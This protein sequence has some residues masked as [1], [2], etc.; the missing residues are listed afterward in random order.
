MSPLRWTLLSVLGAGLGVGLGVAAHLTLPE[1][2][3]VRGLLVGERVL[4]PSSQV[5]SRLHCI[6]SGHHTK[7]SDCDYQGKQCQSSYKQ[8]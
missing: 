8:D 4:P 2:P 5:G 6:C 3:Y 1:S 7:A